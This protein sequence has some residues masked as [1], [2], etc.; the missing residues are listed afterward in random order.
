ML[1]ANFP[2][3]H[4]RGWLLHFNAGLSTTKTPGAF[5]WDDSASIVPSRWCQSYTGSSG[6]LV[7]TKYNNYADPGIGG[8][9]QNKV[10]ILDPNATRW[11][12]R[13]RVHR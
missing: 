10:A 4:A 3:N 13:S 5:G 6:Y 7:L 9:G 12:T 8:N 2:S 11:S 1:E